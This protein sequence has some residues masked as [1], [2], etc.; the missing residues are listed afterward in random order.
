MFSI[1]VEAGPDPLS[2]GI[3]D[4]T[5]QVRDAIVGLIPGVN[6]C[7]AVTDA[8]L[9]A[10]AGLLNLKDTGI[11]SLQSSDFSGLTSLQRLFLNKNRL[12]TLPAGIFSSLV[13]L[14]SLLEQ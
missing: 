13:S 12:T 10:V 4:R 7:S 9:A 6:N 11:S 3:C 8:H 1:S 14:R 5:A 2:G